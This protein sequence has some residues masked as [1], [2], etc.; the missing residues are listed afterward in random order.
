MKNRFR[1]YNGQLL[2]HFMILLFAPWD[3]VW[4]PAKTFKP[5]FAMEMGLL[6]LSIINMV[7]FHVV[8]WTYEPTGTSLLLVSRH[9]GFGFILLSQIFFAVLMVWYSKSTYYTLVKTLYIVA[10]CCCI[11]LVNVYQ[12]LYYEE[13]M[14]LNESRQ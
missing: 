9:S 2:L 4:A 13:Y 7:A 5:L 11:I 12:W 6:A 8:W 14:R 10:Q 3:L 1:D